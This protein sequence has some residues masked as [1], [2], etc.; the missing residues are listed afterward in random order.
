[1]IFVGEALASNDFYACVEKKRWSLCPTLR[2]S[3]L[4]RNVAG[5]TAWLKES[6]GVN[7]GSAGCLVHEQPAAWDEMYAAFK[8]NPVQKK[9][10]GALEGGEATTGKKAFPRALRKGKRQIS[11]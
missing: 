7:G 3:E 8:G 1:M 11:G 2:R 10:S 4:V 9:D 6:R 5:W